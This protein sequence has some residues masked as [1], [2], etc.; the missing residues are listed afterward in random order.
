MGLVD[1]R[2]L[3]NLDLRAAGPNGR[4]LYGIVVDEDQES[5]PMLSSRAI[6][7]IFCGLGSQLAFTQTKSSS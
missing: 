6:S 1:G 4:P 7:A 2:E 3:R 5:M